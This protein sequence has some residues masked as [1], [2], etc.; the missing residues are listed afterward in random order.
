[1]LSLP[2]D[3]RTVLAIEGD[4]KDANTSVLGHLRLEL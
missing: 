2:A 3:W 1:M 4:I